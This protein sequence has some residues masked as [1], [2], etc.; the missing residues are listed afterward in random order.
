MA[1][2]IEIGKKIQNF[3]D[4]N[5]KEGSIKIITEN[6][7]RS[8]LNQ[9]RQIKSILEIDKYKLV[10]IGKFGSGKTTAINYLF[11]LTFDTT[12]EFEEILFTSNGRT[13]LCEVIIKPT[14]QSHSFFEVEYISTE[15]LEQN[16]YDFCVHIFK[17]QNK[18][19]DLQGSDM[20]LEIERAIRNIT[21]LPQKTATSPD[22]AI[23]KLISSNNELDTFFQ[24]VKDEIIKMV[25]VNQNEVIN[26]LPKEKE[27]LKDNSFVSEK[28][29][30]K[31]TY[32]DINFATGNGYSIPKKFTINI[33]EG[34][35]GNNSYLAKFHSIIDT[36]GITK[37]E[38]ENVK[39]RREDLE[40]HILQDDTICLFTTDY[41]SAPEDRIKQL[42]VKYYQ[43]RPDLFKQRFITLVLPKNGDFRDELDENNKKVKTWEKAKPIK[44]QKII[45][46]FKE[47]D[48]H[49][50]PENILFYDAK[51]HFD[52]E[53][54]KPR[55]DKSKEI[56]QDKEDFFKRI[57]DLIEIRKELKSE[58]N[59]LDEEVTQL[60]EQG[61]SIE[62]EKQLILTIKNIQEYSKLIKDLTFSRLFR[63]E[64]SGYHH[65]TMRA[66]HSRNGVYYDIKLLQNAREII[67]EEI[68]NVS[69]EYYERI[70]EHFKELEEF[71]DNLTPLCVQLEK[72]A[73]DLY[74]NFYW[75]LGKKFETKLEFNQFANHSN[76]WQELRDLWGRE[77]KQPPYKQAV[78][79]TIENKLKNIDNELKLEVE[80]S[81]KND[82]IVPILNFL[83]I[84]Y[85][86][87]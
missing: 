23:E 28:K 74:L 71:D 34:I 56:L 82:F 52:P 67:R 33:N 59:Q 70:V 39:V 18:D 54:E 87:K 36:R 42:I 20:P 48:I 78:L 24:S 32:Q 44:Q 41:I 1:N 68:K 31:K 17:R 8:K 50:E 27:L 72:F 61:I 86:Y 10:F 2:T 14:K 7:L 16:L 43:D 75:K 84:E 35:Y 15:E 3:L 66:I 21:K 85:L 63:N 65:M 77:I 5:D 69:K 26:F 62:V 46:L 51:R 13:T 47:D 29:W 60:I 38:D 57:I 4:N 55:K 83:G 73:K 19:S 6:A 40:N 64:Y 9:L 22:K 12:K 53:T 30:I 81:W 49:F 58:I 80:K 79:N 37:I 11:D 76:L 25:T 45:N